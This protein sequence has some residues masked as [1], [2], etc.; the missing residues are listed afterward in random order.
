MHYHN[1]F[2]SLH[3]DKKRMYQGCIKVKLFI[4]GQWYMQIIVPN[5]HFS[6]TNC[7]IFKLI[8]GQFIILFGIIL[9]WP[10]APNFFK[11]CVIALQQ[12]PYI[13]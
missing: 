11:F 12:D 8:R 2:Y 5:D 7:Y 4:G 1:V 9:A 10:Q 6:R 13:F 3:H